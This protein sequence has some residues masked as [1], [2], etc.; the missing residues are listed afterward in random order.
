MVE[1]ESDLSQDDPSIN[2]K[3]LAS[4]LD[5]VVGVDGWTDEYDITAGGTTY[6][7]DAYIHD[8]AVVIEAD[9]WIHPHDEE[10]I[11]LPRRKERFRKDLRRDH[12]MVVEGWE[13]VRIW[14]D[15]LQ[16]YREAVERELEDVILD[17]NLPRGRYLFPHDHFEGDSE[18]VADVVES[19]EP[20]DRVRVRVDSDEYGVLEGV[21]MEQSRSD[22]LNAVELDDPR[23]PQDRFLLE[24]IGL[25]TSPQGAVAYG[26]TTH[27]Y[28][29][30]VGDVVDVERI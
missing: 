11:K 26:G 15:H 5:G 22:L 18:C 21:Y 1:W 14:G 10:E 16:N 9:G 20:G 30:T 27:G 23:S 25:T 28:S 7:V 4:I 6:P 8:S 19:L 12:V 29:E 13:V 24:E 3:I 17:E 2:E